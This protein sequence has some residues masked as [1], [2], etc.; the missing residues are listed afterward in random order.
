[1]FAMGKAAESR[2]WDRYIQL[3]R[4]ENV[5]EKVLRWYV[6][7][8]EQYI[9]AHRDRPLREHEASDVKK[10]LQRVGRA[11]DLQGWQFRQV[12][13]ALQILFSGLVRT[14]WAVGFDWRYW[15]ESSRELETDHPTVARHN[16]PIEPTALPQAGG[17]NSP[18]TANLIREISAEIRRRNYS[19]RTEQSYLQWVRRYVLYHNN[20]DPRELGGLEVAAYLNNLAIARGVSPSTQSQALNALV[21][22]Y[23]QVLGKKLGTLTGLVQAR[24]PRRMPVVLTREE[25]QR[26]LA[27]ITDEPF[28][29]MAGLLYG[30]GMRLMECVRLR[31][32]DV[33]F[34]YS[35]IVV[36]DGKGG[37]DRVVPL[38]RRYRQALEFQVKTVIDLHR[39]DLAQGYGEVFMPDSLARKY[40]NAP[41]EPGW[42]FV[43]PSG[44]LSADPQSKKIRRHHVHESSLQRAIKRAAMASGLHKRISSHTL[45][46]SF[47]T[48]LLESGYD[49]RTVQE[50]LGH[51]DV[52]T[53]MIYTHVLNRPGMTVTSP[54]DLLAP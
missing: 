39:D 21:F 26:V 34:G 20:R 19:I 41:R 6:R 44:K 23:E 24:K 13:H 40:P 7:R 38:P 51:A 17:L 16:H 32:M 5:P 50:L 12:V 9:E 27:V 8:I 53:T 1:M 25:V 47:A 15:L 30:T 33:D 4:Q 2:F 11:G 18:G 43:F 45:R 3:A 42:Q 10:Y 31:V 46:H 37:K 28:A 54:I 14:D 52:S 35:Q 22:L 29:L 49:I 36:R 48:H